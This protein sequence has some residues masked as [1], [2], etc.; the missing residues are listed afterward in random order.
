MFVNIGF[1]RKKKKMRNMDYNSEI[2][3][4]VYDLTH[5]KKERK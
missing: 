4:G 1:G 2:L 3:H 5:T